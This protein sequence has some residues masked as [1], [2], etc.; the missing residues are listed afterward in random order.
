MSIWDEDGEPR[1]PLV[2]WIAPVIVTGTSL[3]GCLGIVFWGWG[4]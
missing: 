4:V 3:I 2:L 1:I